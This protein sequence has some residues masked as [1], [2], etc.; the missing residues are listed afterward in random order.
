MGNFRY[1]VEVFAPPERI[2]VVFVDVERWP[3]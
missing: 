1:T 2:W 3:E